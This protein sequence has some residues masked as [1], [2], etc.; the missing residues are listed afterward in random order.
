MAEKLA[1]S[2]RHS[3]VAGD[4]VVY[5][6]SQTLT[7]VDIFVPL[8][9]VPSLKAKMIYVNMMRCALEFGLVNTDPYMTGELFSEVIVS[10]STWMLEDGELHITLAKA[11]QGEHWTAAMKGHDVQPAAAEDDRKRLLLERFQREHPG[12]DFSGAVVQGEAPD[13]ARF[14]GGFEKQ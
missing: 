2:S 4:R 13:P 14:M 12:M 3:V 6:W 1:P 10:E 11:C 9:P 8:P 5:Q 7:D